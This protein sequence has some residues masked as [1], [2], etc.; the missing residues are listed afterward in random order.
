V[1]RVDFYQVDSM[2]PALLFAC[3]LIDKIYHAGHQI[4]VHT[5]GH[6]QSAELDELIWR[7]RNSRF[8]P[9]ACYDADGKIDKNLSVQISHAHEPKQHRDLLM[10]L[11][12]QVPD[13]F[14]RFERVVEVVPIDE[15]SKQ[16]A[17]VN[18]KFYQDRGYPL[19]YHR[20]PEK[21][22]K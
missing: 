7:F 10:N 8:I 3:R 21:N 9:H 11:S 15:N 4:H 5:Q 17:R 14:S 13:F 22:S 1:T 6:E 18:Y 20:M 2:E 16:S 19:K 12:G